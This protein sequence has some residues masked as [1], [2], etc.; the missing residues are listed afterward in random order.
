MDT[1]IPSATQARSEAV[2]RARGLRA[3]PARVAVLAALYAAPAA[4]THLEVSAATAAEGEAPDRVTLYRVL[5]WLVA[6]GLAHKIA[7][8]DRVW[9]F[10]A[11]AGDD[12]EAAAQSAADATGA[13]APRRHGQ[14]HNH[15]HFH[16]TQC[17]RMFCLDELQPVFAFTLPP[18]FKAEQV[19]V[20][21]RGLCPACQ[22]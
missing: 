14:G 8:D 1:L 22:G 2:M 9:R 13:P 12:P 4:L 18:G 17:G 10:N 6:Q 16:C 15:A 19:E 21:L 5:D 7:G 11:N 20:T 3:T